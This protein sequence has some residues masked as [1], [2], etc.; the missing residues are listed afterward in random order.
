M[1]KPDPSILQG[2]IDRPELGRPLKG[3]DGDAQRDDR[4]EQQEAIGDLQAP[5]NGVEH[6][7]DS[8]SIR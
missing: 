1:I 5:G 6:W 2:G 8:Y 3:K 4:A 7:S